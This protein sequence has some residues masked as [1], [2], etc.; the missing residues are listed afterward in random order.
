[1]TTLG[2][3]VKILVDNLDIPPNWYFSSVTAFFFLS[4]GVNAFTTA[5]IVYKIVTVYNDIPSQGFNISNVLAQA[6]AH[7]SG[8]LDLSPLISILIETGLITFVGQLT[9]S[10]M[11][12]C[13]TI[14]FPLVGGCVVMFYVRAFF[15]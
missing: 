7:G 14:A 3:N 1:L 6:H 4:L 15:C 5:L 2:Y 9:Q 13:A 12:R 11:Y 8:H 10:I